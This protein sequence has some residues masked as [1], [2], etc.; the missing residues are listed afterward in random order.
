LLLLSR[1]WVAALRLRM[2]TDDICI[3]VCSDI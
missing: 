1:A 2:F 3:V